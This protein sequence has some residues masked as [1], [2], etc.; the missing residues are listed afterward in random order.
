MARPPSGGLGAVNALLAAVVL[1]AGVAVAAAR[2]TPD[3]QQREIGSAMPEAAAGWLRTHDPAARIFNVYAWGGY[4]GRELPAARVYIDGRSDIYGDGPIRA[5]ARAISLADDPAPPLAAASVD[6]VV[7]WP[8]SGFADWLD[9]H[10]WRRVHAD[11]VAVIWM[12]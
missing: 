7:F 5:Y 8:A 10:G 1:L 9:A 4:L 11:A 3:V 6:A 2:V 12:R